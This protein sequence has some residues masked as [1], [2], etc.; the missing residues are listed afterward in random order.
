M[1]LKLKVAREIFSQLPQQLRSNLRLTAYLWK[2][3]LNMKCYHSYE[4]PGGC[5]S[6]N[7]KL[8]TTS[9]VAIVDYA[10]LCK[11]VDSI[12]VFILAFHLESSLGRFY[13]SCRAA[14]NNRNLSSTEVRLGAPLL[15]YKNKTFVVLCRAEP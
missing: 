13:K 7:E 6:S 4:S 9:L 1:F 5:K 12:R 14:P 10:S 8:K 3:S 15:F 11:F 2:Y